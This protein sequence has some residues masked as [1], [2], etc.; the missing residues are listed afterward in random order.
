MSFP[1][2]LRCVLKSWK[3]LLL[4]KRQ[5]AGEFPSLP[6]SRSPSALRLALA[7]SSDSTAPSTT[8]THVPNHLSFS[9][10]PCA[11]HLW[12][13]APHRNR[14]TRLSRL[15]KTAMARASKA[16]EADEPLSQQ[17]SALLPLLGGWRRKG[18][19]EGGFGM[20][21]LSSRRCGTRWLRC[22]PPSLSYTSSVSY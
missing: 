13:F 22:V 16:T 19:D 7:A 20:N 8:S 9:T 18:A 12:S 6:P 11:P 10:G 15:L 14:Q 5:Q 3:A 21:R 4:A 17:V 2:S 1:R